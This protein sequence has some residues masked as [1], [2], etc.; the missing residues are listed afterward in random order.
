[1]Y[2]KV[3][4]FPSSILSWLQIHSVRILCL[5]SVF[6]WWICSKVFLPVVGK[7]ILYT[8]NAMASNGSHCTNVTTYYMAIYVDAKNQYVMASM[9]PVHTKADALLARLQLNRQLC[10]STSIVLDSLKVHGC[11]VE[12]HTTGG[13]W[14]QRQVLTIQQI[15]GEYKRDAA[16]QRGLR[17]LSRRRHRRREQQRRRSLDKLHHWLVPAAS[18]TLLLQP[19]CA[20]HGAKTAPNITFIQGPL[21]LTIPLPTRTKIKRHLFLHLFCLL[22]VCA[23]PAT[24]L[25]NHTTPKVFLCPVCPVCKHT[26]ISHFLTANLLITLKTLCCVLFLN[27]VAVFCPQ[28]TYVTVQRFVIPLETGAQ[29]YTYVEVW[30][31]RE[32]PSSCIHAVLL[33]L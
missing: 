27:P 6:Q 3:T 29:N 30:I 23:H 1:M 18:T 17:L 7:S 25:S 4:Q 26:S 24:A 13:Q 22:S 5:P 28:K 32:V 33:C 12:T 2:Q 11:K 21:A 31:S 20:P 9:Q 16:A 14:V 8:N 19:D 10:F 15:S